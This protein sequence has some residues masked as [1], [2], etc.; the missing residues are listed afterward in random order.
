LSIGVTCGVDV[1][2]GAV[3]AEV[4]EEVVIFT[5]GQAGQ[6]VGGAAAAFGEAGQTGRVVIACG[7][8]LI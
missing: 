8:V 6:A 5:A 2:S 1:I 3:S 7:V 4:V